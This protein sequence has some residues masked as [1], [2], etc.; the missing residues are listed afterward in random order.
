MLAVAGVDSATP[1]MTSSKR[2]IGRFSAAAN[3]TTEVRT[4]VAIRGSFTAED[5]R[6]R[7]VKRMKLAIGHSHRTWCGAS[8][9]T[10]ETGWDLSE[11]NAIAIKNIER[12]AA[13]R[14]GRSSEVLLFSTIRASNTESTIRNSAADKRLGI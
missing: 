11:N 12:Y 10:P 14:S 8:R 5:A 1:G 7:I 2:D 3:M 13:L 6:I 4:P 9:P